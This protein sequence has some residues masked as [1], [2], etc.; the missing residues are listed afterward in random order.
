[1]IALA[2]FFYDDFEGKRV[3]LAAYAAKKTRQCSDELDEMITKGHADL[4]MLEQLL[5]Q[6]EV[7]SEG[8]EQSAVSS[9]F[10]A[11]ASIRLE[12]AIA[13][14]QGQG[15]EAAEITAASSSEAASTSA[16]SAPK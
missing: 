16:Q 2:K 1:M 15:G 5:E 3:R 7:E 12:T 8:V 10:T 14:K 9:A 6:V 4:S 11:S 13:V